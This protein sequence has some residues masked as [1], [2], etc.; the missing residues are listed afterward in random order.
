MDFIK[1]SAACPITRVADIDFNL[2][3]INICI[4]NAY[5]DGSKS[6]VF[7][8]L[9]IT[10]YSCGDL[11]MQ[12][13]LLNKSM[14]AIEK[15]V[16]KSKD[17]DMLITV[18]APLNYNNTLYNCGYVIFNGKILGIIPKSFIPNYSE[19]YEKRWFSEGLGLINKKVDF[20]FQKDI[21]FGTNLIFSCDNF[22]F[23]FEICEDLWVTIP[24]SS[25]LAL[26]GANI[27]GNLSASE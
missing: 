2:E 10:S 7:P 14:E 22:N 1:V 6:I 25:Y 26:M 20:K 5:K 17:I 3:N 21:P 18:G 8:E 9:C 24:P 12:S 15:L 13:S 16:Y 27:I 19:F 11:F 4:D 23:G